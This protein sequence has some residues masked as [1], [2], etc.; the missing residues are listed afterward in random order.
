MSTKPLLAD[1]GRLNAAVTGLWRPTTCASA[2]NCRLFAPLTAA[3]KGTLIKKG[4]LSGYLSDLTEVDPVRA[5]LQLL[6]AEPGVSSIV[7]GTLMID[8]L[9]PMWLLNRCWTSAVRLD[10]A[11]D[12]D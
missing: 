3:G 12:S 11:S 10:A 2:R 4:L 1:Y 6:Y 5:A 7:I 9:K 8:H